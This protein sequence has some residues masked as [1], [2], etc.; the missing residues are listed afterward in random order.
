MIGQELAAKIEFV[1]S[2]MWK[3]YLDLIAKHCTNALSIL[4]RFHVVAKMNLAHR[5]CARRRSAAADRKTATSRRSRSR[6]GAC[7]SGPQNL[8]DTQRLRLRESCAIIGTM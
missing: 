8:T 3:P 6:V 7:S 2:D 4:D 1:C 5:R